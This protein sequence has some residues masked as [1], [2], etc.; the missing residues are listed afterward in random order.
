MRHWAG[1]GRRRRRAGG[2]DRPH[3][4][5]GGDRAGL[6]RRGERFDV[7]TD[8]TSA[9]DA[10][11]GYV[12]AE[13]AVTDAAQLRASDPGGIRHAGR[14]LDG[15]PGA[16]DARAP[17]TRRGRLRLRQQHS[18]AGAGGR[19]RRRL[20]LPGVRAG[21]HPAAVLRGKGPFPLGRPVGRPGRH[22]AD[23]RRGTG[24]L[25]RRPRPAALDQ[26]GPGAG[27]VPGTAGRGSAGSATA[28]VRGPDSRSTSWSA[29][30]RSPRP[31]SSAAITST[32]ARSRHPTAR[33]R[34]CAT[35]RTR[36]RTGRCST[37]W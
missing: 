16:G 12:P 34:R 35:V 31:S 13:F 3:R 17:A 8:Q 37:L 2:I 14:G 25:P 20:R 29:P 21:V 19:R 6:R 18:C 5:R 22:P 9:H 33:P 4:Q 15:R 28:S 26:D 30:G 1:R 36:S 23:R 32:Q 11:N 27:A 7:V 10:L 24:A